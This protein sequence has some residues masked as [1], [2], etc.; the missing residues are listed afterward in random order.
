M[1]TPPTIYDL[2]NELDLLEELREDLLEVALRGGIVDDDEEID[3]ALLAQEMA[4]LGV[5][6]LDDVERRM[7]DLNEQLDELEA[8]EDE[9]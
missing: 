6:S 5:T 4:A 8:T 7:V 9:A 3:E 1:S 2:M